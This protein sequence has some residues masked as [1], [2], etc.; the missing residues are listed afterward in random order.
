MKFTPESLIEIYMNG[1]FTEEAQAEFDALMRK[2][3]QFAQSVTTA[4]SE[5]VGAVPEALVDQVSGKLDANIDSVWL[6][7]KPSPMGR[8]IKQ[9]VTAGVLLAAVGGLYG[10]YKHFWP[11]THAMEG[12]EAVPSRSD[13]SGSP[14]LGNGSGSKISAQSKTNL[15]GKSELN[16]NTG[17]PSEK[18]ALENLGTVPGGLHSTGGTVP[19]TS[20]SFAGKGENSPSNQSGL[21]GNM[22]TG[23]AA[24][25]SSVKTQPSL[26]TVPR[27]E[28]GDALRVSIE[29]EKSQK[30]MVTVLDFNGLLVRHL[31]QG[32]W[33]AGVH[34]VDWDGKDEI[35]NQVL[36]GNY[37]VVVNADGKTMS[38]QVTVQPN[39]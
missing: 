23:S 37:T 5:R 20:P 12:N 15:S 32:I 16:G 17:A 7:H 8:V 9:T 21:N 39:R 26:L 38:G 29:T 30:V 1:S 27:T 31:Y 6:K 22:G 24:G 33:K 18:K 25:L 11:Q 4:L 35:G 28:E 19:A 34:L 36:P 2:D 14:R 10:G 13:A 3:P